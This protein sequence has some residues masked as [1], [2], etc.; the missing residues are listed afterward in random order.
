MWLCQ[1]EVRL[2]VRDGLMAV[3]EAEVHTTQSI[4]WGGLG[5]LFKSNEGSHD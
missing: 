4:A 5:L 1:L 3:R 2:L